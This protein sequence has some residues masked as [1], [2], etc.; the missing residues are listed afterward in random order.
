MK[1]ARS[2]PRYP[3]LIALGMSVSPLGQAGYTFTDLGTLGGSTSYANGINN[4]GQIVGQSITVQDLYNPIPYYR[5]TLWE[6]TTITDLGGA[7]NNVAYDINNTGL[8]AGARYYKTYTPAYVWGVGEL[9]RLGVWSEAYDIND[10]G[11]AVGYSL[12][13]NSSSPNTSD[14][15]YHAA[16]WNGATITDL[17][18]LGSQSMAYGI[19]NAGQVVGYLATPNIASTHSTLWDGNGSSATDL[20]NLGGAYSFAYDINEVGQ[21]VG[22]ST[23]FGNT[24]THATLWQDGSIVDLGTLGGT[25]SSAQAINDIGQVVGYS[26]GLGNIGSYRATLWEGTT[27]ID[28]NS[29]LDASVIGQGWVLT[30]ANDINDYGWIVGNATNQL[31]SQTHGFLLTP[32][33]PVPEPQTYAMLL[34]GL[35]LLVL[36]RR[37]KQQHMHA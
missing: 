11:M 32:V 20:G 16:L 26:D 6:G 23:T 8:V 2:F 27:A 22:S 9:N 18:T 19:N 35:G 4:A 13:S 28:L 17:G 30:I 5:A 31:T 10:S 21:V 29:Y 34:S 25:Y 15:K 14:G 12:N 24:A 36:A 1:F 7:G 3:F 37:E 33:S